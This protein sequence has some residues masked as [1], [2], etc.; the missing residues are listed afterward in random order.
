MS[1]KY[2][3]VEFHFDTDR[4]WLIHIGRFSGSSATPTGSAGRQ[5]GSLGDRRQ[6]RKD[7]G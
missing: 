2:G 6:V 7:L 1:R 3:D 4:V 5:L